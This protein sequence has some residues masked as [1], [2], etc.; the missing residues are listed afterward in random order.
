MESDDE[1]TEIVNPGIAPEVISYRDIDS[2]MGEFTRKVEL[3]ER[4]L[5][6]LQQY[7]LM[8]LDASNL[9]ALLDV[10]IWD[11]AEHFSL[12]GVSLS[13]Y[14]ADGALA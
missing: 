7:E 4:I 13:L 5:H 3:N 1:E 2:Q 11:T 9:P 12:T 14:D 6:R 8:L 10:L